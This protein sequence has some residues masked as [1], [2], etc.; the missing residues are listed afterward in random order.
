VD[1]HLNWG[2]SYWTNDLYRRFFCQGLQ[3]RTPGGR[4]LVWVARASNL[5]ILAV[6]L[7]IMTRLSSIQVAWQLSLLLG[8]GMGV[9]LVLR[10]LWWR[11]SAWGELGAIAVSALLAPL[12]LLGL[13][14]DREALRLLLLAV[15][16]TATG[17][18]LSLGLGPERPERLRRFY[19]LVRPPGFWGPVARAAGADPAADVQRLVRGVSAT[20]LASLAVFC[21]LA[22][23]GSWLAGSLGPVWWPAGRGWWIALLLATAALALLAQR[24]AAPSARTGSR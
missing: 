6:A 12:L 7:V 14:G 9:P 21:V 4:E 24:W 23:L 2:A 17:V 16:A 22:G 11:V 18:A 13:P 10:W 15:G 19:E 5:L 8:A 20:L 1:T 3:R